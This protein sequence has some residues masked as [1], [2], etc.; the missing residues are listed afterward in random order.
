MI[1]KEKNWKKYYWYFIFVLF[2]LPLCNSFFV[3]LNKIVKSVIN[4][5]EYNNIHNKLLTENENLGNRIEYYKTPGG[6]KNLIKE[7]LE[8][9]EKDELLIK[10]DGEE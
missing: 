9:V 2:F 8:K 6:I 1:N 7:R 4:Y 3:S 5:S 10:F